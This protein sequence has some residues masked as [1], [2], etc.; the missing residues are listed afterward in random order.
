MFFQA[1]RFP[2]S[3]TPLCHLNR[4]QVK[5]LPDIPVFDS[6]RLFVPVE[7]GEDVDD[8]IQE[9]RH[10]IAPLE[11]P[12]PKNKDEDE[13][14]DEREPEEPPKHKTKGAPV[15]SEEWKEEHRT[16]G[17]KKGKKTKGMRQLFQKTI[18]KEAFKLVKDHPKLKGKNGNKLRLKACNA[19]L[20]KFKDVYMDPN[21]ESFIEDQNLVQDFADELE[22]QLDK[23]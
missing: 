2:T 15:L 6:G 16:R 23:A 10:E 17:P 1:T 12:A 21:F 18:L 5:R 4:P 3:T 13:S 22:A 19:A 8:V 7:Q 11:N 20:N 14:E 9:V